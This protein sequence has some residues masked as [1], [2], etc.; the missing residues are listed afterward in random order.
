M[1]NILKGLQKELGIF[2]VSIAIAS[3][4]VIFSYT[5]FQSSLEDRNNADKTLKQATSRYYTAIN[6]KHVLEK[7]ESRYN[8]LKAKGI[9]GD[10]NRLHWIDII[11]KTTKQQKI[12]Y[13]KYNIEKQQ[14]L[15]S[16]SL[17]AAYPGIDV[18][19]SS[20][21]L[22]MQ[23]LHEGDLFS[24]LNNIDAKTNGLF[25]VQNCSITNNNIQAESLLD[26]ATNMNFA[27]ICTLNWY[28]VKKKSVTIPS[29]PNRRS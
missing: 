6:R 14:K 13:L 27:S 28:T 11:E 15:N 12:P 2:L 24:I 9:A 8:V 4:I 29:N 17:A 25:D 26:S 16:S 22:H 20:M 5:W 7:Y 3:I 23:L 18:F 21:K 10:E 19:R 1:M